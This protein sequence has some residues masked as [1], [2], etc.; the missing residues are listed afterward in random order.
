MSMLSCVLLFFSSVL[1][2]NAWKCSSHG[3]VC[4]RD[5]DCCQSLEGAFCETNHQRVLPLIECSIGKCVNN[6]LSPP[7][8]SL[9][10]PQTCVQAA[11]TQS[12]YFGC[13]GYLPGYGPSYCGLGVS[14]PNDPFSNGF[15]CAAISPFVDA[16]Y[17]CSCN[18]CLPQGV[19]C[20]DSLQCC[21]GTTCTAG[22]DTVLRCFTPLVPLPPAPPL[23][24][25]PPPSPPTPPSPSCGVLSDT[26]DDMMSPC[27]PE[28]ACMA[29]TCLWFVGHRHLLISPALIADSPMC[30]PGLLPY[31]LL[32][33]VD[34]FAATAATAALGT[35]GAALLLGIKER[36]IIASTTASMPPLH[37]QQVEPAANITNS[38]IIPTAAPTLPSP[39]KVSS[40]SGAASASESPV[41]AAP[42]MPFAQPDISGTA[43]APPAPPQ[44]SPSSPHPTPTATEGVIKSGAVS[45]SVAAGL[46]MCV[47]AMSAV[48]VFI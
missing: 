40:L 39:S 38:T 6:S 33:G 31:L 19:P 28:Y 44:P 4:L 3:S 20:D 24:P 32:L 13:C 22:A 46:L 10:P 35:A 42:P 7:P 43:P 1:F 12:G 15:P 5:A 23:P 29:G 17:N 21:S 11:C 16:A 47:A 8:P 45:I 36:A 18:S 30:P 2:T 48:V 25:P 9:P 41:A 26:C 27:C 34:V 14:A 37:L